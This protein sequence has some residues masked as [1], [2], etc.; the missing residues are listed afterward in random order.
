MRRLNVFKKAITFAGLLLLLFPALGRAS[1]TFIQAAASAQSG[2]YGPT[3]TL[4]GG[5]WTNTPTLGNELISDN[6][7]DDPGSW[8]KEFGWA[9]A[10]SAASK[11]ATEI[12]ATVAQ[13]ILAN[14]M[15]YQLRC[16]ITSCSSGAVYWYV[17]NFSSDSVNTPGEYTVTNRASSVRLGVFGIDT[18]VGTVDNMF[19]GQIQTQSLF[20]TRLFPS[21]LG[22]AKAKLVNSPEGTQVGVCMGMNSHTAPTYGVLAYHNGT[23]IKLEYV[24]NGTWTTSINTTVAFSANAYIEIRHTAATTYQ[25]WYSESQ[26]GSDVTI[27]DATINNSLRHGMF[28]T[29]S[30]N[31]I[32]DF[33]FTPL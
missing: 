9:V 30:V 28:S 15:W 5:V 4:A 3:W 12:A 33:S 31:Q 22:T 29:Y 10:D 11:I 7:F 6:G 20:R 26:V 18:F 32:I 17:G 27:N 24:S 25:L 14:S 2:W 8:I 19:C 16:S 23:N 21:S 13:D 1:S